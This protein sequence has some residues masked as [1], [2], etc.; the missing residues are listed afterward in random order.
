[1]LPLEGITVV[2]LEQAVAAPFATRQLADLGARVIKIERPE[3][4][5]FARG[6][7]HAVRGL[8]SHFVWLNRSKESLT[9]DLKRAEAVEVLHRLLAK[10]DVFVQNLAPGAT[11][12]L[13]FVTAEMR[14]KYPRLI[15]CNLSGYGSTGPYRDK[16]AYDMLIQAEAGLISITGTEETPSKVGISVADISCGMYAYSGILTALLVRAKTGEGVAMETSLFDSLGEWMSYAAYY[17]LGGT[18]PPRTGANHA[19]IAPYGPVTSG[20]GKIVYLG[21]QNER[22]WKKFCEVALQRPELA[23]DSRF[24]SNALRVK[25]R[26]ALDAAMREVFGKLT[27]AEIIARLESAQIA[28]ASLNTVQEFVEHPQLKARERWTTVDSPA[29]PL[30]AL[31]PPVTIEGVETA[32]NE[33]PAVGQ[34]SDAI[35]TELGFSGEIIESWRREQ[36]I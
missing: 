7:D 28:N 32:M 20:D 35:L 12:R 19:T 9:L 18:A 31:F 24:A 5:D 30:P 14:K 23:A 6:Y 4:G 25:N 27:A 2:S 34:Q 29:G 22:E 15:I 26:P 21:L 8:S 3:V 10:A 1:M 33:I 36:I 16:K 13:G 11:E 17:M